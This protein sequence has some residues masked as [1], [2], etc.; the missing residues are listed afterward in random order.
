MTIAPNT[1]SGGTITIGTRYGYSSAQGNH[2][3]DLTNVGLKAGL[4]KGETVGTTSFGSWAIPFQSANLYNDLGFFGGQSHINIR[5]NADSAL[6]ITAMTSLGA[7]T[8]DMMRFNTAD[9]QIHVE[10]D[11]RM[12]KDKFIYFGDSPAH[13]LIGKESTD[14]WMILSNFGTGIS[15][16]STNIWLNSTA[17]A[18]FKRIAVQGSVV[19]R[20]VPGELFD[21]GDSLGLVPATNYLTFRDG[22][23]S[24]TLHANNIQ[25]TSGGL[26]ADSAK[27][28][29]LSSKSGHGIDVEDSVIFY[30]DENLVFGNGYTWNG[31]P[32]P[33]RTTMR[34]DTTDHYF[35][36]FA[37]S[38]TTEAEFAAKN[39]TLIAYDPAYDFRS[40]FGGLSGVGTISLDGNVVPALGRGN[41]LYN[42]GY[43][44][45]LG[46]STARFGTVYAGHFNRPQVVDSAVYGSQ[47]AIPVL[48]IN[49][50]GLIDSVGTVPLATTL[51]IGADAG[52]GDVALLD[53]SIQVAGGFNVNTRVEDNVVT[54]HLDSDVLGLTSL[55]VDNVKIDGN[56][57]SSTDSSNQLFID[58]FP[59]GDSGDLVVRGNLIVQGTETVV[60]S[61]VVSLNDKNLILADSA[62]NSSV[63]DGAGITV[64]GAQYSGTKPKFIFDAAT[65]RWDP[66]LPLDIPFASLD[67]AVFLNGVALREVVEDHLNNFF[68]V[69]SKAALTLTYDDVQNSM[70]WKAINATKSQVGVSSF[71][72]ANFSVT[73]GHVA[74]TVL[75]GGTY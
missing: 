48:T 50:S 73:A 59:V 60:N 27:F 32:V 18:G 13:A 57:I 75:D 1:D 47:T 62:A 15:L 53:S 54:V 24:G 38:H 31:N 36:M 37:D 68:G 17:N 6:T 40:G 66:N 16:T 46:A 70:T 41:S 61:S 49:T 14:N 4:I 72:S 43:R 35:E 69:D 64:G 51:N 22:Y 39:I 25:T 34:H 5:D 63:A 30:N 55:T 10:V 44:R 71:D 45:D 11:Q 33:G 74:V 21:I 23:F 8:A 29:K 19:P 58:P 9:S 42:Q 28:D 3:L 26:S 2:K 52:T 65:D 20:Y 56:T 7:A 67:S 12:P